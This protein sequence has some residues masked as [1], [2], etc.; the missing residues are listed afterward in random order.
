ML[1]EIEDADLD[2]LFDNQRDPEANRMAAF[3]PRDREA[4]LAHAVRIRADP[5]VVKRAIVVDGAVVGDIGS[6]EQDGVREVGYWIGRAHWGRGI[7]TAALR[8]FLD[9]V[10]SRPLYAHVAAHNA[11]SIRVLEKTGFRAAGR[12]ETAAD[13]VDELT[14]VLR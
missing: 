12:P 7:A 5:T 1:R 6:W 2:V 11:G 9:L 3:G 14:M 10:P 13:G 4:Y 8:T